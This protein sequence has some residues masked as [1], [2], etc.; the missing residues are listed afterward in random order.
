MNGTLIEEN[1][2]TYGRKKVKKKI[3]VFYRMH[4]QMVSGLLILPVLQDFFQK[5]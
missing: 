1:L 5:T 3:A 4:Y 2:R